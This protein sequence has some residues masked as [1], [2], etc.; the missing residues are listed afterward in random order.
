MALNRDIQKLKG[1]FG[2]QAFDM[3]CEGDLCGAQRVAL[4][5][6]EKIEMWKNAITAKRGE[7]QKLNEEAIAAGEKV[8][9][10]TGKSEYYEDDE[11]PSKGEVVI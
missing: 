4:E 3:V 9:P 8:P 10:S 1:E 6:K 7:I 2:V 11:P 5:H